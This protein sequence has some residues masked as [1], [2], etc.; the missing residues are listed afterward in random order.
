MYEKFQ[1]EQRQLKNK[2][3]LNF[4]YLCFKGNLKSL[5]A[6]TQI[7]I[8]SQRENLEQNYDIIVQAITL[9]VTLLGKI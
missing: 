6:R 9:N 5:F 7:D 1:A 8:C 3:K 2:V 4:Y